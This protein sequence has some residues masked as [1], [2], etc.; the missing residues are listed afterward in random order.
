MWKV[1]WLTW[2]TQCLDTAV[3]GMTCMPTRH[4]WRMGKRLGSQGQSSVYTYH[5]PSAI[6]PTTPVF[7]SIG[8]KWFLLCALTWQGH[9]RYLEDHPKLH[10]FSV[11]EYCLNVASCMIITSAK[12]Y[13]ITALVIK[14]I[15]L[16]PGEIW[17]LKYIIRKAGCLKQNNTHKNSLAYKIM[18]SRS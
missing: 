5:A 10:E 3:M 16:M 14:K 9:W 6:C 2:S 18:S 13:D 11:S 15:R 1:W 7:C 12:S 8:G 17:E 4:P